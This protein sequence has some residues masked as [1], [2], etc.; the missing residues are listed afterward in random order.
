MKKI[1]ALVLILASVLAISS[2]HKKILPAYN[3]DKLITI[4]EAHGYEIMEDVEEEQV[5]EGVTGYIYAVN[6][7]TGDE[8]YYIYCENVSSTN[9]LYDYIDSKQKAK[10]SEL[11]MEIDK[12]EYALYKAEDVSAA[13]KGDYYEQ[14][15]LKSEAL[16]EAKKYGCGRGLNVV[17]YGTKQAIK[18][19][20]DFTKEG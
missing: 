17:W 14:F 2:C 6:L 5:K 9:S 3:S 16:E 7:E 18:D 8:I 15:I 4:L 19:I 13:E 20:K 11:K 10:I 12:I 1:V